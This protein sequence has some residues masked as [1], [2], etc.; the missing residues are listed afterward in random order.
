MGSGGATPCPGQGGAKVGKI[1]G[2]H[3]YHTFNL[4]PALRKALCVCITER[5]TLL[6]SARSPGTNLGADTQGPGAKGQTAPGEGSA[7]PHSPPTAISI[8]SLMMHVRGYILVKASHHACLSLGSH[9]PHPRNDRVVAKTRTL[10]N[11][12]IICIAYLQICNFGE[13][14]HLEI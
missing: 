9:P 11:G 3:F 8:S 1:G 7:A 10:I 5:E 13:Y 6:A 14:A 2:H 12:C 4:P